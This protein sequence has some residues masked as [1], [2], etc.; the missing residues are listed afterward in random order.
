MGGLFDLQDFWFRLRAF[1]EGESECERKLVE[2][3]REQVEDVR[4]REREGL[5]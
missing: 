3:E 4:E 2:S 1:R 5:G